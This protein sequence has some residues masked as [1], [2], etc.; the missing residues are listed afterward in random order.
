MK[1]NTLN[2]TDNLENIRQFVIAKLSR[3]KIFNR[4]PISPGER[5]GS[6]IDYLKKFG[7][8]WIDITSTLNEHKESRRKEFISM[9]PSYMSLIDK[10]GAAEKSE[11]THKDES[12]KSSLIWVNIKDEFSGDVKR[13]KIPVTSDLQRIKLV[14][15][16]LFG[17]KNS[18]SESI[19]LWY[20]SVKFPGERFAL[21]N[22]LRSLDFYS[23]ENEDTIV[24][25]RNR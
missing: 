13:K 22:E 2:G 6:E 24:L 20:S 18:E 4:T 1:F 9:H 21:D 25:T 11:V 14:F 3:L 12:L 5:K 23:I 7:Q 15:L 10:Y 16:K 19:S 17:Y 8:E